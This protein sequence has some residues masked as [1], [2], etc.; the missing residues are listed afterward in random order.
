MKTNN[1][2][3]I[4]GLD[5]SGKSTQVALLKEYFSR[6][7]IAFEYLH[8]PR[9]NEGLYGK[10]ISQYLRG[11]FGQ[12]DEVDPY[13]VAHLYA[14]DRNESKKFLEECSEQNKLVL[15]DRY[16]YSNI[17]FQCAKITATNKKMDLRNWIYDLE[18]N[19]YKIPEPPLSIYL[20]VPFSF[21]Q[22]QLSSD[23]T[24]NDREYLNGQ[25]DIHE[26]SIELQANVHKEYLVMTDELNN[27]FRLDCFDEK[28]NILPIEEIHSKIIDLLQ[29]HNIV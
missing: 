20:N 2:I 14:G 23:R 19:Q 22:T 24:G 25:I 18:F 12:I 16:I 1:I 21:I 28:T 17:A 11:E 26:D 4:E 9:L 27:F 5:G 3:V 13:F 29:K 7:N 6:N 10:L 8:Y 15:L